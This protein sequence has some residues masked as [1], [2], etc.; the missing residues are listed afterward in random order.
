M[1]AARKRGKPARSKRP[2]I[3]CLVQVA[4]NPSFAVELPA[5]VVAR[6]PIV[7]EAVRMADGDMPNL[8]LPSHFT[9]EH[10]DAWAERLAP[11]PGSVKP[12]STDALL[13]GLQV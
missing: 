10:C 8:L 4:G 9:A 6:S 7:S 3:K 2:T 12:M 11:R 5:A 1:P 13:R